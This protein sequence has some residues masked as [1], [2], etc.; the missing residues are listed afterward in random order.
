MV[1]GH[2]VRVLR[3]NS[4]QTEKPRRSNKSP[5]ISD[6]LLRIAASQKHSRSSL[7]PKRD[8]SESPVS[9]NSFRTKS[10]QMRCV[11]ATKKSQKKE[12][13]AAALVIE[14]FFIA[15]KV[16]I[17]MEIKM[18]EE[19]MKKKMS[20]SN[21][22]RSHS[23]SRK[24]SGRRDSRNSIG[25]ESVDSLKE[26]FNR[27][28]TPVNHRPTPL[29][30]FP[31]PK[32]P[33]F[34]KSLSSHAT[35]YMTESHGVPPRGHVN[36]I[37]SSVKSGCMLPRSDV[38][39]SS[40]QN[41]HSSAPNTHTQQNTNINHAPR[42]P[43]HSYA[44]HLPNLANAQGTPMASTPQ[45]RAMTPN[46]ID[47]NHDNRSMPHFYANTSTH[48]HRVT[49]GNNVNPTV[50]YL[51]S[52]SFEALQHKQNRFPHPNSVPPN[53][54]N[55]K[56]QQ[57]AEP[58][59]NNAHSQTTSHHFSHVL[60]APSPVRYAS[61]IQQPV[62]SSAFS[63]SNPHLATGQQ[64]NL[65]DR[66]KNTDGSHSSNV[67]TASSESHHS[68]KLMDYQGYPQ[69]SQTPNAAR[70]H[71]SNKV[72]SST[73]ESRHY[74]N[75]SHVPNHTNLQSSISRPNYY[76]P[77]G[78]TTPNHHHMQHALPS[79]S[80]HFLP[81]YLPNQPHRQYHQYPPQ[82]HMPSHQI[83][84]HYQQQLQQPQAPLRLKKSYN[85]D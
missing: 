59:Y 75:I 62:G 53:M 37:A 16:D 65:H 19:K 10:N 58:G 44:K 25:I 63:Q 51:R 2:L 69:Q 33:P 42:T 32:H 9:R 18:L 66:N 39:N 34:N 76:P 61:S 1:R 60:Y 82:N 52:T 77:H 41:L 43:E 36:A 4:Q 45:N 28:P 78:N 23:C 81:Q 46:G 11:P 85:R 12:E 8:I 83:H 68:A 40:G 26:N 22:S 48:H 80:H 74:Q 20:K 56:Q 27:R 21:R 84:H 70:F 6:A 13:K 50:G 47:L 17:E 24:P 64:Q 67:G 57:L 15:V 49:D 3:H 7:K 38:R 71:S 31:G 14:R 79:P 30:T 35:G 72:Q 5:A 73:P 29:S 54:M 55:I